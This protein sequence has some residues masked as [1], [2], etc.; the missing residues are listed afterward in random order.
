MEQKMSDR[1]WS[2]PIRLND[3]PEAGRHVAIDA[4]AETRAAVARAVG[5]DGIDRLTARLD[6]TPGA[7]DRLRV[8]GNVVATIRQTC[9]VTLEPLTSEVDEPVDVTF[10]P[11][12]PGAEEDDEADPTRAYTEPDPPEALVGGT[13]DLGA[14]ATECLILGIDPYPRKPG[15]EFA[16]PPP[17]RYCRAP[18]AG[19]MPE[20]QLVLERIRFDRIGM[21]SSFVS[22]VAC[23]APSRCPLRRKML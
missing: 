5:V 23:S 10:A 11:P 1:P 22:F 16:A 19:P 13:I 15:A 3:V 6:L 2:A 18:A 12:Q 4:D 9:V 20:L 17:T 8:T 7:G 21:R 14:G